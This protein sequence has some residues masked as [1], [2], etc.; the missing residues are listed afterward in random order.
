M[1]LIRFFSFEA[2]SGVARWLA[3]FILSL[4]F[5]VFGV[6]TLRYAEGAALVSVYAGLG[7]VGA[8]LATECVRRLHDCGQSGRL[9]LLVGASALA[10]GVFGCVY[11]M[12]NGANAAFWSMQAVAGAAFA[13]LLLRP[14]MGRANRY[15]P[16]PPISASSGELGSKSGL[17]VAFAFLVAGTAFR[18]CGA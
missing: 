18:F 5:V 3:W 9:G 14:G 4:G 6:V 13:W 17:L 7:L 10:I 12:A 15:G 8:K 16:P 1:R 2:R 11:W